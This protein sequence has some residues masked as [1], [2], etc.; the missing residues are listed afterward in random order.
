MNYDSCS[1][2]RV[3]DESEVR[4][5]DPGS[6]AIVEAE[7]GGE[8]FRR[9][10]VHLPDGTVGGFT[11]EPAPDSIPGI[12]AWNGSEKKPTLKQPIRLPGRWC[13][14][15]KTG[16][17]VSDPAPAEAGAPAKEYPPP[18]PQHSDSGDQVQK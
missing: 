9:L 7:E 18:L 2:K 16:R 5:G 11:L 13:G 14:Q 8:K 10:W 1:M 15:I 3:A 6:F 17:M 4:S 12:W